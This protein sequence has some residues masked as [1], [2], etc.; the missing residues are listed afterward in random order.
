MINIIFLSTGSNKT[1]LPTK[2][3]STLERPPVILM[4]SGKTEFALLLPKCCVRVVPL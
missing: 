1:H 4:L 3:P 2:I